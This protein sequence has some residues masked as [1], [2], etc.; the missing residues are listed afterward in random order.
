MGQTRSFNCCSCG[1][2]L[3]NPIGDT[4]KCRYCG[5][6][7][8]ILPNGVT[9]IYTKPKEEEKEVQ[10]KDLSLKH[11]FVVAMVFVI[12]PVVLARH[13]KR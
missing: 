6:Y 8:K 2:G 9:L 11:K 10:W 13:Y 1:A 4:S 3:H 12:V 5:N 7:N